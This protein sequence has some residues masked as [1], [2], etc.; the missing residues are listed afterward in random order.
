MKGSQQR[1]GRAFTDTMRKISDPDFTYEWFDF[2][3][4]CRKMKYENL[5]KLLARIKVPFDSFG[6]FNAICNFGFN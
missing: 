2:H 4:E 5:S 1:V 3:A 6:Y